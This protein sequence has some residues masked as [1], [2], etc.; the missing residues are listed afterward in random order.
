M[1]KQLQSCFL[2]LLQAQDSE[3]WA[4]KLC[5]EM[6]QISSIYCRDKNNTKEDMATARGR[7]KKCAFNRHA[8]RKGWGVI[9]PGLTVS[10]CKKNYPFFLYEM[11]K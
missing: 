6:K 10:I 9:I 2:E 7:R 1:I 5:L 11:V 4:Q 8:D 3:G